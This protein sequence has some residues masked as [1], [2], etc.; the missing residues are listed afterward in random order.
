MH[1][2]DLE[3]LYT[4]INGSINLASAFTGNEYLIKIIK[5]CRLKPYSIFTETFKPGTRLENHWVDEFGNS[6]K[7]ENKLYKI[8]M[9]DPSLL[10]STKISTDL[11]GCNS[12]NKIAKESKTAL[13]T[14]CKHNEKDICF[15]A[16]YGQDEY[17]RAFMFYNKWN[18][19]SPLL[20]G[21]NTLQTFFNKI[22]KFGI[23][24][25]DNKMLDFVLR[26]KIE[27]CIIISMPMKQGIKN[28]FDNETINNILEQ[29]N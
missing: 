6:L 20:L 17:L 14:R 9:D 16:F 27:K 18:R 22:D 26:F 25:I 28:C 19:I 2:S 10:D 24:E 8:L 29:R 12:I 15:A 13:I 3:K 5:S 11:F 23:T 7:F 21:M 1:N 4:K